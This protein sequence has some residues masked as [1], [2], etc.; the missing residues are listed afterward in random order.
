MFHYHE[1]I[2]QVFT[3]DVINITEIWPETITITSDERKDNMNDVNSV[4]VTRTKCWSEL[5][6]TLPW[7]NI[8]N[9]II[10]DG[11]IVKRLKK[12]LQV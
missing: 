8:K 2:G 5:N 6:L 3:S 1:I 7:I 4:P 10:V 9:S 12:E 11:K